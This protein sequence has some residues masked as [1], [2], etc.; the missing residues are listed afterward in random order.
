MTSPSRAA[1]PA[2]PRIALVAPSL[3]ILGGQGVQARALERAL[4]QDG[5]RVDFI[6]INPRFP[7]GCRWGRRVPVL[8]TLVNEMLYALTLPRLRRADLV[9]I[10]SASYWSFLLAPVP[11]MIVATL[12][13]RP[14][15]LHYHSGEADDHFRR[16]RRL[17]PACLRWPAAVVVPSTYLQ[18]V[19]ARH[20]IATTVIPNIVDLSHFRHRERQSIR[21]RLL[22]VRNFE[23]YYRVDVTIEAFALLKTRLHDATLTLAGYGSLEREL[24]RLASRLGVPDIVFAG[25]VDPERLPALYDRADIFVNSSVVDNQPVSV[26]EAFAAGLPV[27]STPTGDIA[28]MLREGGAGILV[29]PL[30]R[31][32]MADAVA[33]L[34]DR[35]D[36]ACRLASRARAQVERHTWAAARTLWAS[37]YQTVLDRPPAH[38]A[39]PMPGARRPL[40][41]PPSPIAREYHASSHR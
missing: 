22:S 40:V 14:V 17:F 28:N 20:G 21:P 24:R 34:V 26:L 38:A 25:R 16:W 3:D 5:Y 6:P 30:D 35:P 37:I 39:A 9:H 31:A 19:F 32:A 27:V 15:V 18:A 7:A 8:R 33:T 41:E 12:L 23:P 10:F 4:R 36:L 11:A 2:R 13:G 1:A 29:D